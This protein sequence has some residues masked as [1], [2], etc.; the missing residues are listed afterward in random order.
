MAYQWLVYPCNGPEFVD[1]PDVPNA[2]NFGLDQR[3][4][5]WLWDQYIYPEDRSDSYAVPHAAESFVGLPP[6]V[7][8]TAE[9]DVLRAD[10]IAYRDKLIAA[11]VQV[12]YKDCPGMIH[13][14]F[15]YGKYIDEGIEIRSYF[16]N[17][18]NRILGA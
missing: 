13:G 7:L 9:F 11:G 14:F 2:V 5:K 10:G 12:A 16:A 4:M 15:N 6:T 17:E 18:I 8:I 3:G 1:S